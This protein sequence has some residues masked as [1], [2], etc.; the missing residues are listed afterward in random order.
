LLGALE[1]LVI[2][3]AGQEPLDTLLAE[4]LVLGLLGLGPSASPITAA[5][6]QRSR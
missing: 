6:S 4:R 2:Q 5:A 3:L 1:G